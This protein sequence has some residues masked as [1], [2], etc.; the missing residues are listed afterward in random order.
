MM[1]T[2]R[3]ILKK[4]DV[5]LDGRY[6]LDLGPGK[7]QAHEPASGNTVASEPQARIIENQPE[8]AVI[9]VTCSCGTKVC[10]KCE[11][12]DNQISESA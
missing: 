1:E 11:Y 6:Q 10:L 5:E 2:S 4:D 8:Y 7:F 12:S 3:R 9:E